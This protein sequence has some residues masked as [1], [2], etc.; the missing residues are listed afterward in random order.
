[1]TGVSRYDWYRIVKF[2]HVLVVVMGLGP[3]IAF[4]V[5]GPRIPKSPVPSRLALTETMKALADRVVRPMTLLVL[6]TGVIDVILGDDL[7]LASFKETWVKLGIAFWLVGFLIAEIFL[8]RSVNRAIAIQRS[9][10]GPP[11]EAEMAELESLGKR[12]AI[13]GGIN[14]LVLTFLILDM[15]WKFGRGG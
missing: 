5:I 2:L 4:A 9:L 10:T 8:V 13:F 12:Q 1:V 3:T 15:V 6:I 11:S 14:H 7:G